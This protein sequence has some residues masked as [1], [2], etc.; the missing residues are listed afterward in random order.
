MIKKLVISVFLFVTSFGGY[1]QTEEPKLKVA[2]NYFS[3]F[4]I[5]E[6]GLLD[7][8]DERPLQTLEI[9]LFTRSKG[10]SY[11]NDIYNYPEYGLSLFYTD[12]G[13]K[14]VLGEV[15]GLD[16]FFKINLLEREKTKFHV[17]SGIGI[18]YTN[19]KYDPITN[20]LNG[21]VGSNVNTHFNLRVG[22]NQKVATNIDFNIGGSFDHISNATT[23]FPN[24]GV[25][26][27]SLYGGF[28]KNFGSTYQKGIN[29]IPKHEPELALSITKYMG[30]RHLEFPT[31]QYYYVP[32][33]SLELTHQTFRLMYLGVGV[34][35]FYDNSIEPTLVVSG[36]SF[37]S[38]N[39]LLLGIHF[40]QTF[41]YN[42]FSF[43]LQEGVYLKKDDVVEEKLMYNRVVFNYD[44]S[45]H[46]SF[47]MGL[48]TYLH[49][50]RYLEPGI[51]YRW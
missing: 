42:K 15:F 8:I 7:S 23:Q 38:S 44:I 17:R 50:L 41:V 5:P 35:G 13:E 36:A 47:K 19:K 12:L 46:I 30:F 16:Y 37:V 2:A 3:G 51:T 22:L 25:N 11:W 48:R 40:S 49:D 14:E 26:Y 31:D 10:K 45:D 28:T 1:T 29:D 32:G 27:V 39:A 43:T 9:S 4:V 21:S 24:L 6:F 33:L 34:D 18:N 20:P